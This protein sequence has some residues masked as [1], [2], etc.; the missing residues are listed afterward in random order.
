MFADDTNIFFKGKC[1]KSLF[2][3]CQSRMET[4]DSSLNANKLTLNVN[5]KN[6]I[7]FHTP[8]NQA[9]SNN[10]SL[11][12]GN[13]TIKRVNSTKFLEVTIHEYLSW[14]MLMECVLKRIRINHGR[15]RKVSSL[16][17]KEALMMLYNS[18]IKS[19]LTYCIYS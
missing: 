18:L 19:Y 13:N 14:K 10:L 5:K 15:V 12:I 2:W 16:L 9:S 4:I 6:F 1:C 11:Y 3:Y 7:V 8:S 17:N